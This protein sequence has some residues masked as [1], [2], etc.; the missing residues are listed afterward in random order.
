[1]FVLKLVFPEMIPDSNV[2]ALIDK[3]FEHFLEQ[4]QGCC[5]QNLPRSGGLIHLMREIHTQRGMN[6]K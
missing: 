1:M 5:C 6:M 4:V 2:P 3:R